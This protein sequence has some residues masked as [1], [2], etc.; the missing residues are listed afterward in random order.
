MKYI[1][2]FFLVFT[3]IIF[4]SCGS[5]QVQ[6]KPLVFEIMPF[7]KFESFP[8]SGK[9]GKHILIEE[10]FSTDL[11]NALRWKNFSIENGPVISKQVKDDDER[12][13]IIGIFYLYNR[14]FANAES[15]LSMAS[16]NPNL[17]QAKILLLDAMLLQDKE[18]DYLTAYQELFDGT[19]N[20]IYKNLIKERFTYYRYGI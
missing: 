11:Q 16:N 20:P 17:I 5:H 9:P 13:F 1:Y 19:S 18:Y 7:S 2:T 12:N 3:A 14:E 8:T 15:H 10:H 4:T 6:Y